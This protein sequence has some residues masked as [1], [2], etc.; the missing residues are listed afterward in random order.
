MVFFVVTSSAG[1]LFDLPFLLNTDRGSEES[2][3]KWRTD[4]E[5]RRLEEC[6]NMFPYIYHCGK[7]IVLAFGAS[8][9]EDEAMDQCPK[10][11]PNGKTNPDQGGA[12]TKAFISSCL[13]TGSGT[14]EKGIKEVQRSL[15]SNYKNWLK[16]CS[17]QNTDMPPFVRQRPCFASSHFC[18]ISDTPL[19]L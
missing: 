6:G 11:V 16:H 9:D 14:I 15:R 12:M 5:A 7:G 17:S 3:Y 2:L 4:G 1:T 8:K 19:F 10:P 18:R 13:A